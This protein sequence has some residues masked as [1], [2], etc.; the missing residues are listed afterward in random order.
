MNANFYQVD[1]SP[2]SYQVSITPYH[3]NI[4]KSD[5]YRASYQKW[6][7]TAPEMGEMGP[8]SNRS[9]ETSISRPD[10]PHQPRSTVHSTG[11]VRSG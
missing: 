9:K 5:L 1:T 11:N 3:K 7:N 8:T 4:I 6:G 10:N 2:V